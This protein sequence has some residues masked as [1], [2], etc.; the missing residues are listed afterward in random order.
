M[1]YER[2]IKEEQFS[3][4]YAPLIEGLRVEPDLVVESIFGYDFF[5]YDC[6]YWTDDEGRCVTGWQDKISKDAAGLDLL[7]IKVG[8]Q[9]TLSELQELLARRITV[10]KFGELCG[11]GEWECDWYPMGHCLSGLKEL[12]HRFGLPEDQ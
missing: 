4:A 3:G 11:P 2:L 6:P 10:Q 12:K 7:G 9:H 1:G 8:A 5:C